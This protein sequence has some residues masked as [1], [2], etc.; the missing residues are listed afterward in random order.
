ML[1]IHSVPRMRNVL[2]PEPSHI[3]IYCIIILHPSAH[4]FLNK[5]SSCAIVNSVQTVK[6]QPTFS[7]KTSRKHRRSNELQFPTIGRH[8]NPPRS[9][10]SIQF[11]VNTTFTA[12]SILIYMHIRWTATCIHGTE[13]NHVQHFY[14]A[15]GKHGH[16][17]YY[18]VF[19]SS[20]HAAHHRRIDRASLRS[21]HSGSGICSF[22]RNMVFSSLGVTIIRIRLLS[23]HL[24]HSDIGCLIHVHAAHT[25]SHTTD[26]SMHETPGT[27]TTSNA[28]CGI[29]FGA[30]NVLYADF[31]LVFAPS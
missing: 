10:F 8:E 2:F 12:Y 9:S 13:P 15:N 5:L 17:R 7:R 14:N 1:H 22:S 6:R 27:R 19:R 29:G 30:G 21:S 18:S 4:L 3:S 16:S 25:H 11:F 20:L 28:E 24:T 23:F 31:M 26:T